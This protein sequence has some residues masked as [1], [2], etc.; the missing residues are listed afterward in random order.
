VVK[1]GLPAVMAKA[2]FSHWISAEISLPFTLITAFP[3]NQR[4]A[5]KSG[6]P[7]TPIFAH[8]VRLGQTGSN[9][10]I[11]LNFSQIIWKYLEMNGLH[12][13]RCLDGSNPVKLSQTNLFRVRLSLTSPRKGRDLPQKIRLNPTKSN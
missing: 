6:K 4:A 8:P 12:N 10:C 13:N 9:Q 1:H 11:W 5:M 7:V 2:P 3:S